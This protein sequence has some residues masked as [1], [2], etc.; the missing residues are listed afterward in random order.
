MSVICFNQRGST[1]GGGPV[2]FVYKTARE[3]QKRGYRV[4]YDKPQNADA[5]I[6]IIETGKFRRYCKG[7]K[8]KILL[9]IDGI[10]NQEYNKLFNR[11]IR[12]D[13][14]ALHT[15]L[16]SDIPN[17]HHVVYQS[18][19]SKERIDEEICPRPDGN[20]SV[21][22]NGVDT[23]LFK[24]L[25]RQPD[26][27]IN[28]IHIGKM[29]DAYLM[30]SLVGVYNNL[31]KRG[32]KV[33]LILAGT[34]DGHC[35]NV[36]SPFSG[37]KD[38]RYLGPSPN[39]KLTSVYGHGDIFLGPRQGSSSD[40]VI[41]EAQACGLPVVIP[42]WGGNTDM[43]KDKETGIIVPTGHWDYGPEYIEKLTDGAEEIIKLGAS[44]MGKKARAHAVKELG[45]EKMADKYLKALG[46]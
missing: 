22:H 27:T 26:G 30:E 18:N 14:T 2:T 28:L 11:A 41:A 43:V 31:K 13:M 38:V 44:E 16:A 25:Q 4:T 34:M 5:A 20:W 33:A 21:V 32:H 19:W 36:L 6:C 7:A 23:S 1:G 24:P 8:T 39:T 3:L 40:N 9:R 29:R 35:A 46:L 45:I 37:D 12:P 15:K 10:Y 42:S 17:V